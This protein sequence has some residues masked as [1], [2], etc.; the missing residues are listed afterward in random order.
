MDTPAG[1]N[2]PLPV[3]SVPVA[4]PTVTPVSSPAPIVPAVTGPRPGAPPPPAKRS[5]HRWILPVVVCFIITFVYTAF[6]LVW[7]ADWWFSFR[8]YIVQY[9][10]G[11]DYVILED[12]PLGDQLTVSRVRLTKPGYVGLVRSNSY[13]FPGDTIIGVSRYL[14]AG[15]YTNVMVDVHPKDFNRS[16]E[17]QTVTPG[18]MIYAML[19]YSQGEQEYTGRETEVKDMY[20]KIVLSRMTV[21]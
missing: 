3:T 12:Q 10:F 20:G 19:F 7:K 1:P 6:F 13:G 21:E 8:Q 2:S 5:G 16:D 4:V 17:V 11:K 14:P 15:S 18:N 9:T